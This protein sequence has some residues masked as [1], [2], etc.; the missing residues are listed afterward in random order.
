MGKQHISF[1]NL[2]DYDRLELVLNCLLLIA[3]IR[4][5]W[6]LVDVTRD[7]NTDY[8]VENASCI[9]LKIWMGFFSDILKYKSIMLSTI[10]L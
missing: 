3:N 1:H 2:D 7:I 6:I 10:L 4:R 8:E 5:Y 9:D